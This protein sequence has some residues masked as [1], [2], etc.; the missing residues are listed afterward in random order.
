MNQIPGW[1]TGIPKWLTGAA[2]LF[3]AI[4]ALIAFFTDGTGYPFGVFVF[5]SGAFLVATLMS[6]SALRDLLTYLFKWVQ[7]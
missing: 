1:N 6:S 5:I 3:A 7:L 2:S 4:F